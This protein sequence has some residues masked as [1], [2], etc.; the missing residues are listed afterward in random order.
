M[1]VPTTSALTL[2]Q[3]NSIQ[4]GRFYGIAVQGSFAYLGQGNSLII[5]NISVPSAP[6]FVGQ[7]DDLGGTI[8][9]IAISGNYAFV[10]TGNG[11]LK[12]V[13]ISN[14]AAPTVTATY[15][16]PG[17][18]EGVAI[19]GNFAY[20]TDNVGLQIIN[21]SNPV[22][23][24]LAGSYS[25][26]AYSTSVALAGNYA[27]VVSALSSRFYVINVSNPANPTLAGVYNTTGW[28]SDVS[29]SG[30]YAHIMTW[31]PFAVQVLNISNPT[32][33]LKVGEYP[34]AGSKGV[35][36]VG[37]YSYV[38]DGDAFRVVNVSIPS[39][40]SLTGSYSPLDSVWDMVVNG[41]Y[42]YTTEQ[43]GMSIINIANPAA[44][45]RVGFF[46]NG[47][48]PD[49][50]S[51]T[52]T[53]VEPVANTQ[54]AVVYGQSVQLRADATDNKG[55]TK[56]VFRRWDAPTGTWIILIED[57]AAP[58]TYSLDSST[59][60][61]GWN[62]VNAM[63]YD[64]AGNSDDKY[65]WVSLEPPVAPI[66]GTIANQDSDGSYNV[67]WSSSIGATGYKL[68]ENQNSGGWSQI[69]VGTGLSVAR[70]GRAAGT[71]CYR[72]RGSNKAG[73]GVWSSTVCTTVNPTNQPP[74]SPSNP[75]PATGATNV[76][77]T[78]APSWTGTDPNNDSLTY[79][80][81]FGT[82]NPP[83]QAVAS[84]SATTY[85]P[86]GDLA[87]STTYY[88]QIVA[89]DGRGG[90][91][92]GPVWS[93]TTVVA[94]QLFP[95]IFFISP[96]GSATIGGIPATP[97]DIL[98]YTK[99]TNSWTMVYDGS[100]RGTAKNITAF[101]LL[102][103]GSLLLVFG[104]N[105]PLT[106][107]G[108]AATAT[109]Y[110]IVKFTPNNP[111]VYPLGPGT[112]SWFFQGKPNSLSTTTEKIDAL[113]L[114]GDRLLLST[115]GTAKLPLLPS[116]ILTAADEDVFAFNRTTNRWESALVIDGSKM[117]GM[118]VEDI[119]SVW[120]DSANLDYY[121]TITGAFNLGG[122]R[123]NGKSIVKLT[124]NGGATMFTPS[125][126]PWL[127]P[128]ATF[129]SNLDGLDMAR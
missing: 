99:S 60:N 6:T 111:G 118:A 92:H 69:Y 116:G 24:F 102:D 85:D 83:P 28:P 124:P 126:V 65:I 121:V 91:T 66:I 89:S 1:D 84:Q 9:D 115:T 107:G 63:A 41:N 72:V 12:I 93:F 32:N 70:T 48:P 7:S 11:Q 68:E 95:N 106:I 97:A 105:Q 18:V 129:P 16:A 38:S 25:N 49:T 117:A 43:T 14:P 44:P 17:S 10:G 67:S 57:Y 114:S 30:N 31:S 110:D 4:V 86:P 103:D 75:N 113:D 47:V 59:L 8:Y 74:N 58:Y 27:Y 22:S 77:V 52:V 96:S 56:V 82:T 36:V 128:G 80:V 79:E 19:S 23:P 87:R 33:I 78:A 45:N 53:W 3:P 120:Y 119:S 100:V 55:V 2:L 123:G 94:P 109:P 108:A 98:R 50:T 13:N 20:I 29:V 104:V 37:N 5:S 88:W 73:D 112:Y 39:A 125:L 35:R 62:Q 61:T 90:V 21:I 26:S 64:A 101:D 54:V 122:V 81:R 71:W 15:T 46:S 40:P 51:P 42:A 127:A 34:Y 76:A